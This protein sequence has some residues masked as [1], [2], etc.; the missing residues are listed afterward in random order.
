MG[1]F[2]WLK[3]LIF[4]LAHSL[5]SLALGRCF[6]LRMVLFKATLGAGGMGVSDFLTTLTSGMFTLLWEW[7]VGEVGRCFPWCECGQ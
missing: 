7:L 1:I 6:L 4:S 3:Y 2:W 5:S